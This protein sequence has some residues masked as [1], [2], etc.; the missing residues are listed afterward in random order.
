MSVPLI[1]AH[2][3]AVLEKLRSVVGL[4]VGDGEAPDPRPE[5]YAVLY[6]LPSGSLTG[7]LANPNEDAELVYQVQC[8][9]TT[10]EQ[11]E[12]V[13][14]KSMVL[15][16]GFEVEDRSIAR[17]STDNIA[18]ARRDDAD[19]PPLFYAPQRFRVKTTPS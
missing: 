11:A 19:S 1:R 10:R 4:Q 9:G 7:S 17:V 12:W 3:D 6:H 2:T 8:I 16:Q 13:L 15:L 18:S 5:R 14:D